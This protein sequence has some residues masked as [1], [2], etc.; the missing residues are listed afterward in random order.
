MKQ[1]KLVHKVYKA[2]FAHDADK[3]IELRKEEF[4]KILKRRAQGKPFNTKWT[5]VRV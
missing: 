4:R 2:C 3:L 1:S 5:I